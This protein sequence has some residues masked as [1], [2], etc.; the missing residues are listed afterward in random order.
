MVAL[1]A[2]HDTGVSTFLFL[3]LPL[4]AR[5]IS[6]LGSEQQKQK[7][8][9]DLVSL[10]KICGWA[11][12]EREVGSNSTRLGTTFTKKGEGFLLNGDKRWIGN[13][14]NDLLI[15]YGNMADEKRV[16]GALIE[17][18]SEGLTSNKI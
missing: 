10:K 18:S 13:G 14:V 11:L 12:T 2:S 8:L 5:T 16:V 7:Y 17:N 3:Q 1:I 4:S 6:L 9:P 15:V